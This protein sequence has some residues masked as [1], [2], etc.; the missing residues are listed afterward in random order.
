MGKIVRIHVRRNGILVV[1]HH[2]VCIQ[3]LRKYYYDYVQYL[4]D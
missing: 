1:Y 2:T 4:E 3:Q